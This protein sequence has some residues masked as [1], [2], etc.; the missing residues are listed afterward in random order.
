V[1]TGEVCDIVL[2]TMCAPDCM[3]CASDTMLVDESGLCTFCGNGILDLSV[4]EICDWKIDAN[5]L[6]DCSGCDAG[7]VATGT[8]GCFKCGNGVY[9]E[10]EVCDPG[11]VEHLCSSDCTSC[12]PSYVADEQ[13]GCTLCGNGVVDEGEICDTAL[14]SCV[15]CQTCDENHVPDPSGMGCTRCGNGG[16]DAG[17][18]C[19]AAFSHCSVDCS[20][21]NGGTIPAGDTL[22]TCTECGN[23]VLDKDEM[24][25]GDDNCVDCLD[26]REPYV[27]V[28]GGRCLLCGNGRL[29]PGEVCDSAHSDTCASACQA[30]LPDF[31]PLMDIEMNPTGRCVP[32]SC[33]G[34]PTGDDSQCQCK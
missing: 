2:D 3:G 29:D 16:L 25:D 15:G 24:C 33:N 11:L 31:E 7:Q 22:G 26:C 5:C 20:S 32:F 27:L 34:A 18:V 6:S 14:T 21:C 9:D 17:E 23:G 12:A 13:G 8:G 30:C 10:G 1:D 4:G 19:D 28:P